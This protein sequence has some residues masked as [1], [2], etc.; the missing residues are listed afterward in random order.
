MSISPELF[1]ESIGG[2]ATISEFC[3]SRLTMLLPVLLA[4]G[5]GAFEFLE[6]TTY[7]SWTY[8]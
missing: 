2:I 4:L 5:E 7:E 6:E 3:G 1:L 8:D